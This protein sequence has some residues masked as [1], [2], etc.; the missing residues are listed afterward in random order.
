MTIQTTLIRIGNSLGSRYSKAELDKLGL[1]E[2]DRIEVTIRRAKPDKVKAVAALRLIAEGGGPLSKIDVAKWDAER[3][4][5]WAKRDEQ[6]R[7]ISRR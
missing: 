6:L 4:A 2:G 7:D 1:R 5:A 3:H